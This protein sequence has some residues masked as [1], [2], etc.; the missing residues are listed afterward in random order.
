MDAFVTAHIAADGAANGP[1]TMGVLHAPGPSVLLPLADAFT[2]CD[3]YHC[4]VLGPTD[5]NRVMSISATIDPAGVAGGPYSKPYTGDRQTHYGQFEWTTMPERLSA[6]GISWKVYNDPTSL[7][8]LSPFPYF[9]AFAEPSTAAQAE[10]AALALA[11]R[12]RRRSRPTSRR[13][14]SRRFHGSCRPWRS[15]STPRRR[16]N[17][18]SISSNRSSRRWYP[19]PTSGARRCSSSC[20]TRTADSST[21]F[22]LRLPRRGPPVNT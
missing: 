8:E 16:R 20:T 6:A 19:T 1:V 21:T 18:A 13:E 7:S 10:M 14:L 22:H 9:K 17:T 2:I 5:P 4:S 3:A 12:T 11:P 15:A